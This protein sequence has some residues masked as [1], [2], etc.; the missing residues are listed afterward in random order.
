M[1][2]NSPKLSH[3]GVLPLSLLVGLFVSC[4]SDRGI[5]AAKPN[6]TE[7]APKT[8]S[9]TEP[10]QAHPARSDIVGHPPELS[11]VLTRRDKNWITQL[12]AH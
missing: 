5:T 6:P 1:N 4:G 2:D 12:D 8:A 7:N 9:S 11:Q 10:Q 3:W